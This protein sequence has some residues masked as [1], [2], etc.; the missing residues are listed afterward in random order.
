MAL[1]QIKNLTF[2]YDGSAHNVFEGAS[3]AMDTDWRLGL[4][5]RNGRGKTTLL[6]LLCG[7]LLYSGTITSPVP[8]TYFP[9]P[10][11]DETKNTLEL[12]EEIAPGAERWEI[13]CELSKLQVEENVLCRPF[14][15]LSMGERTKALLCALFLRPGHFLLIDEPTNHLDVRAREV[16]GDYLRSK[17]GFILVSHD[18]VLLDRCVDHVL[19]IN[20]GTIEA[21]QGNFSSWQREKQRR[22][23]LE[24]RHNE[25][26]KKEIKRLEEAAARAGDWSQKTEKSKKGRGAKNSGLRPDRGFVGHKAAKMMKRSKTIETRSAKAAQEKSRLLKDVELISDLRLHPLPYPK[27]RLVEARNLSLFYGERR[28]VKG[29][30][31]TIER[32][33]RLALCGRNGCG[34]STV[35]KALL[36]EAIDR[37][38]ELLLGTNIKISYV[39]Q[40][41]S[42]LSGPFSV[43]SQ[44]SGVDLSL[45]MA[46]LRKLGFERSQFDAPLE[47]LS[48]GQKKK[49]LLAKSLCE[50]AHLYLWDEPLNFVDILSRI[51]LEELIL[52]YR[53]TMVFVEHD[54]A[55]LKNVATKN[56]S[57]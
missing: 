13:E 30:S 38:G 10:V 51:Q 4:I 37:Q 56:V 27:Q 47:S 46:L 23:E 11:S 39:P 41:A 6:R 31:F 8:F 15:T 52:E 21:M 49:I 20:R 29:V 18:R 9:F 5:G 12:L 45:F 25:A 57:L 22:D 3:F 53:P 14:S 28:V 34:K 32:G 42:F 16:V 33:D 36:G 17:K 44:Q 7:G 54:R 43:F 1:I 50:Q 26:L 40:D 55:F 19:S 35:L 48:G 2:S 24:K